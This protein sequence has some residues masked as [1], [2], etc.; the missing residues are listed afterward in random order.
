MKNK[1]YKKFSGGIATNTA[2]KEGAIKNKIAK[3]TFDNISKLNVNRGEIK[4][5]IFENLHNK[6]LNYDL[7]KKGLKATVIDNNGLSD[8][9]IKDIKTGKVVERIQAK[10]GYEGLS[11][12]KN[13]TR[14]IDDGQKIVINNDANNFKNLLEKNNIP[15]EKSSITDREVSKIANIMKKEGTYLNKSNAK[16]TSSV[17]KTKEVIK[18]CHSSGISGAKSGATFGAGVSLGSNIVQVVCGDKDLGEATVD[19]AKDTVVSGVTG[20]VVS[21]AGS[22]VAGTAVGSAI[23][24][25][26]TAAGSAIAGTT[27]GSAIVSGITAVS[28]ATAS[29]GT[30]IAGTAV[31][32]AIAGTAIGSAAIAAAP[33]VAVGAIIGGGFAL[34]GKIFGD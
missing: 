9:V 2:I 13:L 8:I 21:A 34:I 22:A 5:F 32:S 7:Y 18:N 27:V 28:G 24:S 3:E 31:G 16:I 15:Y 14:Y 10:C 1:N 17:Y 11:S 20:Y 6:N 26:A 30:T 12:P 29:V 19:I 4:G 23:A 33:V 25:G